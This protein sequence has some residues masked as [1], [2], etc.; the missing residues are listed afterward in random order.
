MLVAMMAPLLTAP[1]RH[2]YDRSLACR[3]ARAIALFIAGYAA[4]WMLA[5][6]LLVILVPAIGLGLSKSWAMAALATIFAL[7]WQFSPIKQRSLNRCHA[8][9]ELSAFGLTADFDALRFGLKHSIWCVGSCWA[10]M[11]LPLLLGRGHL[12]AMAVV[13]GLLLSE[14]LESPAPAKWHW[15]CPGKALRIAVAQTRMQLQRS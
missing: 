14:R 7:I 13:T 2:I 1:I 6:I 4:I 5:G 11:M 8:H 9:P 3:R 15:R 12:I 10:L